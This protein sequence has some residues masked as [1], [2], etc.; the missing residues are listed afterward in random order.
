MRNLRQLMRVASLAAVPALFVIGSAYA[1]VVY[2]TPQSQPVKAVEY[3]PIMCAGEECTVFATMDRADCNSKGCVLYMQ[4]GLG[5][6][7]CDAQGCTAR[8]STLARWDL[9]T[10][11]TECPDGRCTVS[12]TA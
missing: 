2:T 5:S 10:L 11:P 6:V 3:A 1:T 12:F 8:R 4:G 7:F 9:A